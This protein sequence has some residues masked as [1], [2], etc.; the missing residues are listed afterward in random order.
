MVLSDMVQFVYKVMNYYVLQ[1]EWSIIWNDLEIGIDWLVLGDCVFLLLE[2][3]L[4]V[5]ILVIVEVYK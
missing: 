1:L 4:Q 3:D 5:Y 2:K